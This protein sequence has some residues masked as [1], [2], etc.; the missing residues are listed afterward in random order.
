MLK[1]IIKLYFNILFS[2]FRNPKPCFYLG[3][4]KHGTPYFLP[5]KWA[6]DPNNPPYLK[7]KP[8]KYLWVQCIPLGYKSKYSEWRFEWNPQISFVFCKLQF[9]I[10]LIP[11]DIVKDNYDVYWEAWLTYDKD[12]DHNLSTKERLEQLKK[13]FNFIYLVTKDKSTKE[14]DYYPLICKK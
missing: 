12:T 13:K 5:R 3:K 4:I 11:P 6:K 1:E 14:I 2:P 10:W 9:C 8:V 7:A